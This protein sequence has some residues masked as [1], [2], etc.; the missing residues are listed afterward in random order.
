MTA[1]EMQCC[2]RALHLSTLKIYK[3]VSTTWI[4]WDFI[5]FSSPD[6]SYF[7]VKQFSSVLLEV[8]FVTM[9]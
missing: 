4:K 5:F 6:I 7:S 8:S 3:C 2:A 9:R 1:K